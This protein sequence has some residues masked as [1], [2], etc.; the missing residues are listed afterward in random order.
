[1]YVEY[2]NPVGIVQ[3]GAM[4]FIGGNGPAGA[5]QVYNN[6]QW[7]MICDNGWDIRDARVVCRQLGFDNVT[8]LY[9]C[10]HFGQFN[11]PVTIERLNC[12]GAEASISDCPYSN[13]TAGSYCGR[14][15]QVGVE[16]I[17]K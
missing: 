3:N 10:S 12:T 5:V 11:Y 2:V 7:G 6:G 4:R 8:N 13:V 15:N 14:Y 17:C 9:C 1:M 16:C